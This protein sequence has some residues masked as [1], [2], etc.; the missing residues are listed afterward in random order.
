ME[1]MPMELRRPEVESRARLAL[2]VASRR[3]NRRQS[4]K[5]QPR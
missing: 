2:P 5:S 4:P 1:W 3:E